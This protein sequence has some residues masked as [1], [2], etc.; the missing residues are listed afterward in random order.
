MS[1]ASLDALTT[2]AIVKLAK[3]NYALCVDAVLRHGAPVLRDASLGK[4]TTEIDESVHVFGYDMKL[5]LI[6]RQAHNGMPVFMSF[7]IRW[8]RAWGVG[9]VAK[10][11]TSAMVKL[12]RRWKR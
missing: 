8:L 6:L 9:V 7:P 2:S 4:L 12:T 1:D 5:F 10:A 11:T 3:E